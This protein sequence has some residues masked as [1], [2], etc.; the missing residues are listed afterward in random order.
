MQIARRHVILLALFAGLGTGILPARA[1]MAQDM[2]AGDAVFG[3]PGAAKDV[4]RTVAIAMNDTM[5]FQPD[6]LNFN[7][8]ETVRLRIGNTGKLPHEFVLGTKAEIAEH[9]AMMRKHPGMI[10]A[11]A[12]A[13]RLA[14]G[15]QAD[16][17]WK[18]SKA[19]TFFFACLVPGHWEA[20]MQ[21]TV[22]VAE[23]APRSRK[24]SDSP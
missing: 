7:R 17:I 21:G 11:D 6:K 1:G 15:K 24:T 22:T 13:A 8:G 3:Q 23:P 5:R 2:P 16:V 9:A 14:P 12:N 4:S 18:F 20:G 10:H 19:G